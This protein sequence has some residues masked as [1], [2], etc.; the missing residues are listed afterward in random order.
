MTETSQ[1][2]FTMVARAV[3]LFTAMPIHEC[4]HGLM[5]DRLGDDTPRRQGRLTLNPFAHL[6][7]LGGVL[8]VF[9]GFGWAKPVQ[10]DPRNFRKP[11]RDMAVT[12][13]AG[14]LSNIL[15]GLAL[16]I[17]YRVWGNFLPLLRNSA[18]P[19]YVEILINAM[20]YTNLYLAVFNLLPVPPLDGSKIFGAVLPDRYYFTVM[21]YERFI[22]IALMVLLFTGVLT[23]PLSYM[24]NLLYT[25]IYIITFPLGRIL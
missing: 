5:A 10:V 18:I 6:D 23:K 3:V 20:V 9:T 22:A 19:M 16:M 4:A 13:L 14:P 2:L 8:L 24:A 11:R 12:S 17:L 7:L 25:L 1:R 15:L 21:R